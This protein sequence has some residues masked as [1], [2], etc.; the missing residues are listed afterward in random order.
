MEVTGK[1]TRV[2]E[3]EPQFVIKRG[4]PAAVILD[5]HDYEE[6]IER[7]ED[8]EDLTE[9]NELRKKSLKFRPF[10]EFLGELKN[11]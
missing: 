11:V 5:I 6:L 2:L 1:M 9:L 10:E 3:K 4:K 8:A 7:F